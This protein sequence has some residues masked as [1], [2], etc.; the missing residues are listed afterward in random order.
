MQNVL[1]PVNVFVI[2]TSLGPLMRWMMLFKCRGQSSEPRVTGDAI[3]GRG[4][5]PA[6]LPHGSLIEALRPQPRRGEG[7]F[8]GGVSVQGSEIFRARWAVNHAGPAAAKVVA[9][10]SWIAYEGAPWS[11]AGVAPS[12]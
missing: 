9:P 4:C 6:W 5:A 10:P 7:D 2:M 1:V 3:P 8:R 12:L 11:L